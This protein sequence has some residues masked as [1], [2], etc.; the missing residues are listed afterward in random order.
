M[1]EEEDYSENLDKICPNCMIAN[2]NNAENCMM[3]DKDLLET[4]LFL[5][6]EFFDIE[7]TSKEFI[8]YRK[9]YYRTRRTG[10]VKHFKLDKMRNINFGTPIKRFSFEYDG[11]KEV[12]PLRDVN[13]ILLKKLINGG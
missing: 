6:D 13:F 12:Y 2:P 8:E 5:E 3:C 10:K 7:I 1:S 4:V 9:N 11:K